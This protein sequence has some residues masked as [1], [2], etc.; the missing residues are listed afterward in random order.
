MI[1]LPKELTREKDRYILNYSINN[2]DLIIN[3]M[4]VFENGSVATKQQAFTLAGFSKNMFY[5]IKV[6]HDVALQYCEENDIDY[7]KTNYRSVI[8]TYKML[9]AA[10]E[11]A[12]FNMVQVAV[13]HTKDVWGKD[14]DGNPVLLKKGNGELALKIAGKMSAEW[15]FNK[16]VDINVNTN[17]KQNYG[18]SVSFIELDSIID[19]AGEEQDELMRI[20]KEKTL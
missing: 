13:D 15:D 3:L 14:K 1:I 18:V 11:K 17:N 20:T 9:D 8:D 7:K 12:A 10:C 16:T 19:I 5:L 2:P 4:K 6:A